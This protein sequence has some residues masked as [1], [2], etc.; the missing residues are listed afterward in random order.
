MILHYLG[1]PRGGAQLRPH[2][3][4]WKCRAWRAQHPHPPPP[5]HKKKTLTAW[6]RSCDPTIC[7]SRCLT[8]SSNT[9]TGTM[10]EPA[11]I[12]FWICAGGG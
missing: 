1:M 8:S 7:L 6:W 11:D 3:I 5:T 9:V 12:S 2:D 10:S 4:C